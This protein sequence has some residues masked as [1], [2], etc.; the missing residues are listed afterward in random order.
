MEVDHILGF[1]LEKVGVH[2]VDDGILQVAYANLEVSAV[3]QDEFS[4]DVRA[5]PSPVNS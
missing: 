2:K 1:M 5:L 3:R 4:A